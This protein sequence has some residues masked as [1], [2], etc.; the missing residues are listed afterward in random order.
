MIFITI[1]KENFNQRM[2][3][4]IMTLKARKNKVE[5]KAI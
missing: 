5:S 3:L 4:L 2:N 1:K